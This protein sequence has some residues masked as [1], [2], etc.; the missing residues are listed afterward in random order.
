ME[1]NTPDKRLKGF[2]L[3]ALTSHL[4]NI[5][6]SVAVEYLSISLACFDTVRE[7]KNMCQRL[8]DPRQGCDEEIESV[9]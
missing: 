1:S 6:I 4:D 5:N 7:N 3:V 2:F 8:W 9:R